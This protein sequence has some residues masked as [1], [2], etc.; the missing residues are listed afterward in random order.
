[1]RK[2]VAEIGLERCPGGNRRGTF[3]LMGFGDGRF[4]ADAPLNLIEVPDDP[5]QRHAVM[6]E[7]RALLAGPVLAAK[8]RRLMKAG[9]LVDDILEFHMAPLEK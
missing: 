3:L 1:M 8:E 9:E 2:V 5:P 6:R 4:S 7:D